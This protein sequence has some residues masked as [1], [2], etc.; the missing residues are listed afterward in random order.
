MAVP[1]PSLDDVP[2]C[3]R[4]FTL[5]TLLCDPTLVEQYKGCSLGIFRLA[6]QDYHRY[7]IPVDGTY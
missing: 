2:R 1:P 3:R 6:P 5:E 4:N 7:H